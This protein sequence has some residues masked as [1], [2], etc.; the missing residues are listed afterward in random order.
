[1]VHDESQKDIVFIG[2]PSRDSD[3]DMGHEEVLNTI[4]CVAV[5]RRTLA[6]SKDTINWQRTSIFH[7]WIKIDE[8]IVK[9]LLI[10]EVV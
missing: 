4:R 8:K 5:I 9:S 10:V 2:N 6:Q 7:T 1:M 3:D